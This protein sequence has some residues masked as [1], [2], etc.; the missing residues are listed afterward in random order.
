[1]CNGYILLDLLAPSGT[2]Q[3]DRL[4]SRST[5]VSLLFSFELCLVHQ[6]LWIPRNLMVS[7]KVCYIT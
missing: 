1:V 2:F 5:Q 4:D 3:A 6:A 7:P